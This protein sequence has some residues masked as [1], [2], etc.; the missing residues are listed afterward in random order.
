MEIKVTFKFEA[1]DT[2]LTCIENFKEAI[3]SMAGT[4]L[5]AQMPAKEK[6]VAKAVVTKDSVKI[7]KKETLF[8]PIQQ[9]MPESE[10]LEGIEGTGSMSPSAFEKR[11]EAQDEP[12]V[13]LTEEDVRAAMDR[14]RK[15]IEG[16]DYKN[17]TSGDGYKLYHR[18]LTTQFK[19]IASSL[20][21]DKPSTLPAEQREAFIKACEELHVE[22]GEIAVTLPF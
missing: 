1:D 2:L 10:V 21:S 15:R 7:T 14:T 17:N 12:V 16:E 11:A 20:G 6:G 22:N 3:Q 18:K 5:L 9:D 4:G 13:T 19:N 8:P